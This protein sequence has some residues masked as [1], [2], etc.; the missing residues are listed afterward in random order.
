M[1]NDAL[2]KTTDKLERTQRL[3]RINS[4]ITELKGIIAPTRPL[5]DQEQEELR[6]LEEERTRLKSDKDS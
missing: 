2:K 6:S 4:R 3:V 1:D 5:T